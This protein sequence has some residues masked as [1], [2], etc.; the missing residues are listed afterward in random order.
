MPF[1]FP[2]SVTKDFGERLMMILTCSSSASSS[3]HSDALKNW[4]GLRAMTFTSSAPRRSE[5]RQQSMAVLPTPMISTFLPMDLMCSK[6]TDSSQV[7]PIW[8][9]A[10]P[11]ARPGSFSSLPLGAPAP[12]NTASKPPLSNNSR[13]DL[14]GWLSLR[15]TPMSTIWAISS[16][17]TSAGRRND[18]MLVRIR[19]PG[20]PHCSKMVTA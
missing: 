1:S 18:G 19:P 14:I 16:L 15:S 13:M 7:M 12:T 9:L 6:A 20:T 17:S 10:A 8:M 11:S 4:R 2:P 5:V 3:S